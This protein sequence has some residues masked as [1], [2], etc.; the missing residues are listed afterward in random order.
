MWLPAAAYIPRE[1]LCWERLW[2]KAEGQEGCLQWDQTFLTPLQTGSGHSVFNNVNSRK[3]P[4][5]RVYWNTDSGGISDQ[6]KAPEQK[7]VYVGSDVV[8]KSNLVMYEH[9]NYRCLF[10]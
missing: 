5:R 10:L 3:I 9:E 2:K 6:R 4:M 1:Q 8:F 7:R